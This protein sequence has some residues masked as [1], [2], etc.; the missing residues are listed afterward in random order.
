[1]SSDGKW[2][3]GCNIDYISKEEDDFYDRDIEIYAELSRKQFAS[4]VNGDV[5]VEV[6]NGVEMKQVKSGSRS[7][8]FY[9]DNKHSAKQLMEGLDN[10]GVAWQINHFG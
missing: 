7:L 3:S 1:M 6:P 10:S 5:D 9:C 4:I 8:K 2:V